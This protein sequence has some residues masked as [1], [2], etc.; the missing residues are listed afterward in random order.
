[1]NGGGAGF[2]GGEDSGCLSPVSSPRHAQQQHHHYGGL[3]GTPRRKRAAPDPS[4]YRGVVERTVRRALARTHEHTR[5]HNPA[6]AD[7]GPCCCV[8]ALSCA[9]CVCAQGGLFRARVYHNKEC[10]LS[11]EQFTTP[12]EA[13]PSR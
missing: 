8:C 10:T 13:R 6:F 9:A 1:V 12:D 2:C 4:K 7:K 5:A 11:D 3:A